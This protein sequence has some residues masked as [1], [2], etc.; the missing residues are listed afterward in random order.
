V[1]GHK[2]PRKRQKRSEGPSEAELDEMIEQA[3]VAKERTGS[4]PFDVGPEA[5]NSSRVGTKA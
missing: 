1:T 5:G 2:T 3:I 4:R